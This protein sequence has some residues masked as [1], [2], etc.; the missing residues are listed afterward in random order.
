MS[1]SHKKFVENAAGAF[2]SLSVEIKRWDGVAKLKDAA[3]KAASDAHAD[4]DSFRG[5]V[6]LLG[7][8]HSHLKAV[9]SLYMKCYT[10]MYEKTLPFERGEY[11]IPSVQMPRVLSDLNKLRDRA[12]EEREKFI[13]EYERFR[14]IALAE[15]MGDWR[16]EVKDKYPT[17]EEIRSKFGV[18]VSPPRPVSAL[19][20]SKVRLPVDVSAEVAAEMERTQQ[21]SYD[22]LAAAFEHAKDAALESAEKA[23]NK[24]ID[25]VG[26][27]EKTNKD[28]STYTPRVHP[29]VLTNAKHAAEMLRDMVQGYDNDPRLIKLADK[30]EK[31]VANVK[32]S[33][34]WKASEEKA[35]N[36]VAAAKI[37]AKGLKD[38]RKA[39]AAVSTP[40]N[41]S[42]ATGPKASKVR[43]GGIM[44]KKLAKGKAKKS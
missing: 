13:T 10:Y 16:D 3:R 35:D 18:T 31:E 26:Q 2:V 9:K 17:P 25:Q 42:A 1:H 4:P 37:V 33:T 44:G 11:L 28:G 5:Y 20:M 38:Y 39:R 8:Y 23:V 19:D 43:A 6:N 34:D 24:V 36:A 22:T 30:I 14:E 29:S 27:K 12:D 15:D 40:A 41:K 21:Q 32:A 7:T